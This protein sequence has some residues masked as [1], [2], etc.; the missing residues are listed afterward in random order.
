MPMY[1]KEAL[2]LPLKFQ[3]PNT[4]STLKPVIETVI[5][6]G[7]V[8]VPAPPPV[9]VSATL[10]ASKPGTAGRA[11]PGGFGSAVNDHVPHGV[12]EPGRWSSAGRVVRFNRGVTGALA[13]RDDQ[14]VIDV[15]AE[16][17]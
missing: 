12:P 3:V 10:L 13:H 6:V 4:A 9:T 15:E 16:A 8:S 14:G 11:P 17:N 7:T 2:G 5:C 1:G